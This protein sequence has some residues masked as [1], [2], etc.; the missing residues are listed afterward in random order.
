MAATDVAPPLPPESETVRRKRIR[1]LLSD[2]SLYRIVPVF[3]DNA[4]NGAAAA[5]TASAAAAE[6]ER[7]L[8]QQKRKRLAAPAALEKRPKLVAR[9]KTQ[10]ELYLIGSRLPLKT[11]TFIGTGDSVKQTLLHYNGAT[12][13]AS[14]SRGG[15]GWF[16]CLVIIVPAHSHWNTPERRAAVT[17]QWKKSRGIDCRTAWGITNVVLNRTSSPPGAEVRWVI[18]ERLIDPIEYRTTFAILCTQLYDADKFARFIANK[19]LPHVGAEKLEA[20]IQSDMRTQMRRRFP[21]RY[22]E[23]LI[24]QYRP[25]NAAIRSLTSAPAA[26]ADEDVDV[27]DDELSPSSVDDG[28]SS[29]YD[30]DTYVDTG[31]FEAAV[32]QSAA[33]ATAVAAAARTH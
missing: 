7:A 12:G 19:H 13:D 4:N 10:K 23:N 8:V 25:R 16:A 28:E 5:A 20:L 27:D 1:A 29:F 26:A 33:A 22:F 2:A 3:D 15:G 11:H 21:P 31:A 14:I 18:S 32:M 30:Q 24:E 9:A 6:S 17:A